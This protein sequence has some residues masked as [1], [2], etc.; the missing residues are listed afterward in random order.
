MSDGRMQHYI[1]TASW[2]PR[3]CWEC[4][5]AT[6]HAFVFVRAHSG[7]EALEIAQGR[8]TPQPYEAH[9]F[10]AAT[11]LALPVVPQTKNP[12]RIAEREMFVRAGSYVSELKPER[13]AMR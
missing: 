13:E 2:E 5:E 8:L 4:N 1:V 9:R 3:P 11:P 6:G 7:K 10:V 12:R